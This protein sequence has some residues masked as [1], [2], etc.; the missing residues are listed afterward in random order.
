MGKDFVVLCGILCC[1]VLRWEGIQCD[2]LDSIE[3]GRLIALVG[4][5]PPIL[6]SS[7]NSSEVMNTILLFLT[8]RQL[9]RLQY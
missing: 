4:T 9:Y 1:I 8:S 3:Y 2:G 6:L 7:N 5:N